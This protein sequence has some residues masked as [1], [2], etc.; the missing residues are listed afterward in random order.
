MS[1]YGEFVF[2]HSCSEFFFSL[3]DAAF[4]AVFIFDLVP[5]TFVVCF[6]FF[7]RVREESSHSFGRFVDDCNA[8]WFE[9]TFIH[10]EYI[11]DVGKY[12]SLGGFRSF[13]RTLLH[14]F[15]VLLGQPFHSSA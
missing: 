11:F 6:E 3:T 7:F 2:M 5:N 15:M 4:A 8:L 13:I 12:C 9:Q 10:F 1:F 14:P